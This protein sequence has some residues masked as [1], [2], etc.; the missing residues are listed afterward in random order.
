M[1][2]VMQLLQPP[3]WRESRRF[4]R[5]S[6]GKRQIPEIMQRQVPMVQKVQENQALDPKVKRSS[7]EMEAALT[8][9]TEESYSPV[10]NEAPREKRVQTKKDS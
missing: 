6:S 1:T 10:Q 8:Q 2:E 7:S 4:I 9:S 3:K 5:H